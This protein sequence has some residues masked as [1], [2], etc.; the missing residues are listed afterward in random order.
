MRRCSR[1]TGSEDLQQALLFG[2]RLR[3]VAGEDVGEL[4]GV[5]GLQRC[6]HPFGREVVRELG[7]LLEQL[8]QLGHVP[9]NG[10][11]VLGHLHSQL[12]D[13]RHQTA[14]LDLDIDQSRATQ[15]LDHD[16]DVARGE[17]EVLDDPGDMTPSVVRCRPRRVRR[18]WDPAG[19][20]GRSAC[21]CGRGHVPGPPPTVG[22][23]PQTAPSCGERPPYPATGT[24][25][26]STVEGFEVMMSLS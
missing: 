20:R 6:Q 21:R 25:G 8:H 26:S 18:S 1:S 3:E 5:L 4:I 24:A 13:P 15:P 11:F 2:R 12:L 23:R 17:L 16:L 10:S 19:W 22:G 7:V 14:V 9:G